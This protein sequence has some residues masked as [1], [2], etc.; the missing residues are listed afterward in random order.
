[1]PARGYLFA[2]GEAQLEALR[3]SEAAADRDR[4]VTRLLTAWD[5]PHVEEVDKAWPAIRRSLAR[6][7]DADDPDLA[8]ALPA[9]PDGA[10][11]PPALVVPPEIVPRV[12]RA[13]DGLG[14]EAFRERFFATLDGEP[15]DES[16]ELDYLYTWQWFQRVRALYRRAAA[17][18][19]AVLFTA[20]EERGAGPGGG[21]PWSFA[22]SGG[23]SRL[24]A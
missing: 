11:G 16:A 17:E 14:E 13:L 5:R 3:G 6:G 15:D 24:L 18:G 23:S 9:A 22:G 8:R 10:A 19:R 7:G 20:R 4:W 1:M 12:A 2:L 21:Q